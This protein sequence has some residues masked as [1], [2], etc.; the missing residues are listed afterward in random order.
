MALFNNPEFMWFGTEEKMGWII[1][2]NTGAD[3]SSFGNTGEASLENGGYYVRNS[4]DSA[5]S[6]Q[7]SW[8]ET[9]N[10]MLVSL[11]QAY[12]NGS[13]GRGLI[14]FHDPMYYSTNILPK[15][16]AD[17]SMAVNREA[18]PLLP[19]IIP[20]STPVATTSNNYPVR[21]ANYTIPATFSS[22]VAGT[23]HF[24]PIPP[25]MT[26]HLGAS[27]T[28]T[29]GARVYVRTP[30]GLQNLPMLP[31]TGP[32]ATTV[33]NAEWARIG[34]RNPDATPQ[35]VSIVGVTGRLSP[36]TD[37]SSTEYSLGPWYAG[38]GHSGC[39]FVGNP[40]VIN[41]NGVDGGQMGLS[42]NLREVGAWA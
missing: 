12:R 4:W 1:T 13:Y 39:R 19:D 20:T 38:E 30:T 2:P 25:G 16:W 26:L 7:F 35:T 31:L 24:I 5:K 34:I 23:E 33:V 14:W 41:Y 37:S 17:P 28:A 10:H 40:T 8:G 11:L 22:S 18:E 36:S 9:A 6:Y 15:R 42:V 3:V 27:Y 21:A 32:V 29:G